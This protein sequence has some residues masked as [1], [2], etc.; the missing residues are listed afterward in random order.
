MASS[1][2]SVLLLRKKPG[3]GR[4]LPDR[5][6]CAPA[7]VRLA[8]V[9]VRGSG[10]G[11]AALLGSVLLCGWATLTVFQVGERRFPVGLVPVRS[12]IPLED[13]LGPDG[14]VASRG[15]RPGP[16]AGVRRS[17]SAARRR[18][19]GRALCSRPSIGACVP[20]SPSRRAAWPCFGDYSPTVRVR[21]R[22]PATPASWGVGSAQRPPRSS[23]AADATDAGIHRL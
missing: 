16:D 11:A 23:Q 3:S 15:A 19:T 2:L 5:V 12:A 9:A 22:S 7:C 13:P 14:L 8:R 21:S 17:R 4:R 20:P 10:A 18:G 1:A 6:A